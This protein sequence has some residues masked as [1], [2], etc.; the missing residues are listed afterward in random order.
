MVLTWTPDSKNI[1]FLT[2][3]A[4]WNVSVTRAF[5]VPLEGGM[6]TPLPL[7]SGS[8]MTYGPDGHSIAYTRWMR[9]FRTW[10]R[11]DGGLA[12]DVWTY[13]FAT[14]KRDRITDW[15]GTDTSPMWSGRH[16]YFLSDRDPS[17]RR[18]IWSYDQ[19]TSQFRQITH[20]TDDD[21]EFPTL[22]DTGIVFQKADRLYVID[23]PSETVHQ[24]EV[25]IPDDGTRTQPRSVKVA[26]DIREEDN[27]Q[28]TDFDLSPN[29]E[30]AVFAAR[31]NIFT[32][33][34]EHG[35]I[36]N[37]TN[38]SD[39]DADHPA[40]SPD[41]KTIAYTSDAGGERQLWVRPATSTGV[42]T[43]LTHFATGYVYA[44][45]FS[46]DGKHLAFSDN[47][48]ALWIATTDGTGTPTRIA[49][50]PYKEIHDQAWSPDGNWLAFS[51]M[52]PDQ[53]RSI[54]LHDIAHNKSIELTA[55]TENDESPVF[56][57]DG[58]Y[59]AFVSARHE[60]PTFSE[61]EQDFATL[62][63][64]GI[65]L[66]PLAADAASPFAPRS[67]EG[68][69]TPP[70]HDHPTAYK[71]GALPPIHIDTEGLL[72]RAVPLPIEPAS[73]A[74][75]EARPGK[76]FYLTQ[77]PETIEG[78]LPG[79][80]SALHAYDLASRKDETV[81]EDLEHVAISADGARLLYKH[82]SDWIIA[83]AKPP[84]GAEGQHKLALAAMRKQVVPRQEWSEM[85][86]DAW[87][88]ERDFF[89]STVT[90]GVNWQAVRDQYARLVPLV[91]SRDDLDDVIGQMQ[92]ELGNSHTYAGA[93]GDM[94]DPTP[95]VPTMLLG[96]D[97]AVDGASNRYK[98]AT[99]YPG[100]PSR[101][102]YRSP[103]TEPGLNVHEG[104][105]LLAVNGQDLKVPTNPYS[106]FVGLTAPITLTIA[107]NPTAKP[108][109]IVVD[110]IRSEL[111][112][113]EL[114]WITH[115]RDT[116]DRLSNGRIGYVYL[117]D[118]SK[119]GLEQFVRQFYPQADKQAMIIDD[120]W[121]GGGFVDSFLL[122]RLRRILIGMDTNRERIGTSVPSTVLN[123]PKLCLI[124]YWSASD[125]D[126][127]PANF[128]AYGL[129]KLVGTRTWGGVRGIRGEW[130]LLDGGEMTIPEFG[131]Y[132]LDSKWVI[133]NHGV[134]PDVTIDDE[135][136]EL[137]DGHDKQLETG[138]NM[139]LAQLG[140]AP[141][142]LPAP[143]PLLPAYPP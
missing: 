26:A 41:G 24:L 110:P 4:A 42:P 17:R 59:L 123:G 7:D 129:G 53:Q 31:G 60:N 38:A 99:I 14:R 55:P 10:K 108:R 133:E 118:M 73:L 51:M 67:D 121:N 39:V 94:Q 20:F 70:D 16:I 34:A 77:A 89:F 81:A 143:P 76:L 61:S 91:G 130:K 2:R 96:V 47:S 115:N 1:V 85:F 72:A 37:L 132:G 138:V 32:V 28:Q 92:G 131:R 69:W 66:A 29:G 36:R 124:N 102:E 3:G 134:D 127:F 135:P 56:T 63:T 141:R 35:A 79:E 22:G 49:A 25:T 125:G 122:D 90:N 95:P 78:H 82:G 58:K 111:D 101:P 21:I 107:D 40:W 18:N 88:L 112:V 142:T 114:A 62:K 106:L 5:Q 15:K 126:I 140:S 33:P 44:P 119:H 103:L 100:D 68:A 105:V 137:A 117:S 98:F 13:D 27:A 12:Q 46:P 87:R 11:Y 6:P 75:L 128:R 83:D 48:H 97:F 86:T 43:Q 50:D 8:L 136:A 54:W 139:L 116:V 93:G 120:R 52:R 30:R 104:T 57:T 23:L 80:K 113:R 64:Q 9:D 109:D 19:D 74:D 84:H 45:T 71:P 65:Y